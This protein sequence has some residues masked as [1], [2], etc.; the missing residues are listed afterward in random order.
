MM[1]FTSGNDKQN[2]RRTFVQHVI[3]ASAAPLY[4]F[5]VKTCAELQRNTDNPV[6]S[7]RL[8]DDYVSKPLDFLAAFRRESA[9]ISHS[10]DGRPI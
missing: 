5:S 3:A 8:M 9:T 1:S 2:D 7:G 6:R 4:R 10:Y